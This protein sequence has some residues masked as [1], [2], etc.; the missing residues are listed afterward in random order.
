MVAILLLRPIVFPGTDALAPAPTA[1]ATPDRLVQ[2]LTRAGTFAPPR[3]TPT[4]PATPSGPVPT[5]EPDPRFAEF[6]KEYGLEIGKECVAPCITFVR[7]L[8]YGRPL[9]LGDFVSR[10]GLPEKVNVFL[11]SGGERADIVAV[12]Y[13]IKKGF[14]VFANRPIDPRDEITPD[15]FV[16]RLDLFHS[17]TLDGIA[18]ESDRLTGTQNIRMAEDWK[19][20]GPIKI[21]GR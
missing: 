12:L 21:H 18:M 16:G 10:V 20:F 6:Q 7:D 17:R 5:H 2:A 11:F 14:S 9:K 4:H 8:A 19:G 13:Y 1:T 15:M 3:S